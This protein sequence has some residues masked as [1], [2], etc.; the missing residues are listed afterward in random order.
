MF[1]ALLE[2]VNLE[3]VIESTIEI[4]RVGVQPGFPL[5]W[6]LRSTFR[7][8]PGRCLGC[9]AVA[10]LPYLDLCEC[11]LRSWPFL[12][13]DAPAGFLGE[14][15]VPFSFS[16]PID[17]ALRDLKFRGDWRWASVLGTVMAA[18]A[19]VA[20]RANSEFQ[21]PDVLLPVPLHG[22]R[23]CERGFNQAEKLAAVIGRR[24][25][26]EVCSRGLQRLRATLAQTRLSAAARHDNLV[27]AFGLS[28]R[29]ARRLAERGGDTSPL[30]V[31]VVDDVLTTGATLA[32]AAAA[33]EA[34]GHVVVQR[35]A[36]AR[37]MPHSITNPT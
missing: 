28:R 26:I 30:R 8:L 15:F 37:T 24:L 31:A 11:C 14:P 34:S 10:D 7:W 21:L 19:L 6:W 32:A 20:A 1:R 35:W 5:P 36:I 4:L 9:A 18:R 27:G 25:A 2:P 16:S 29:F 17:A 33:L 13:S 12:S 23:R 22:A 3:D